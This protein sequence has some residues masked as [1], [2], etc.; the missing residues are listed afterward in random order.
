MR[1]VS[2]PKVRVSS[3]DQ[4]PI[5]NQES[6][7]S[8]SVFPS[9]ILIHPSQGPTS[10][11]QGEESWSK[12]VAN[13][14]EYGVAL[15]G[16]PDRDAAVAASAF[17]V[18]DAAL[19]IIGPKNDST[20]AASP[21]FSSS[22]ECCRIQTIPPSAS[23][24]HATGYHPVGGMSQRYNEFREGFVWSD[25]QTFKMVD[26]PEFSVLTKR[27]EV[28]LHALTCAVMRAVAKQLDIS[29]GDDWFEEHLGPTH[30]H[31]Q[32]HI[33]R[34]VAASAHQDVDPGMWLP[35]H[36]DPSLVSVVIHDLAGTISG[37]SGF[38]YHHNGQWQTIPVSG[39]AVGIIIVGSVLQH[40]TGGFF[41]ACRHR[42]LMTQPLE[43][44]QQQHHHASTPRRMAAT[45]FLR[46]A[47]E[48]V[49]RS[50]M[51][52]KLGAR[53]AKKPLP[54]ITF[55]QWLEKTARNYE[56]SQRKTKTAESTSS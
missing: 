19:E 20:A 48:A 26:R 37:G 21:S 9:V 51:S 44:Q 39:H 55:A 15:V 49:L 34:F 53:L 38:Q 10:V 2:P 17:R 52:P 32:W 27:L 25:G 11:C 35:T 18:A 24:A 3:Y 7:T 47:S 14:L 5:M 8:G 33:K 31:S 56:K 43:Q 45:Y 50:P 54:L 41:Q 29:S 6:S 40:V 36:T 1:K 12:V 4:S 42:V 23:S 16:I 46:P 30:G 13:L 28:Q 22:P